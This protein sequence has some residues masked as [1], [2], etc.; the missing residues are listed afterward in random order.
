MDFV[1]RGKDFAPARG[2]DA[3]LYRGVRAA[4]HPASSA[5]DTEKV[6]YLD[7]DLI[8]RRCIGELFDTPIGDFAAMGVADAGSPF[9]SSIYG[10]P[11]WPRYGRKADD[12]NFNSGVLLLNL[13]VLREIDFTGAAIS[14]LTD[15]WIGFCRIRKPSTASWLGGSGT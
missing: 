8:A 12:V 6:L 4:V 13:P 10:V 5:G 14:Y 11:F 3:H 1:A 2:H 15:G 7:C 9:V